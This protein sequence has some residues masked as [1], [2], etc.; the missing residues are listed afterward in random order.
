[1]STCPECGG[2][3]TDWDRLESVTLVGYHSPPGHDHDD[4]CRT[5]SYRCENGHRFGLS[6]RNRCRVLQPDGT[7]CTWVGKAECFCCPNGK[8]DEWPAVVAQWT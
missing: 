8:I 4:N 3:I 7:R 6:R 1:M 5:R 2:A